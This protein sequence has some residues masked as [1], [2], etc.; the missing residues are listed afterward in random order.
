MF[1][2]VHLDL[3]TYGNIVPSIKHGGGGGFTVWD[4]LAVTSALYRTKCMK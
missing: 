2:V 3:Q 4:C 1:R